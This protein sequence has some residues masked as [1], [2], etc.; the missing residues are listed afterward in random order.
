MSAL[1]WCILSAVNLPAYFLV[2]WALFKDWDEFIEAV[3]F[4]LKPDLWSALS[5]ELMDDWWAEMKL[6]FFLAACTGLVFVEG[7][8][9]VEPHI[10]PL[11]SYRFWSGRIVE[12]ICSYV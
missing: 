6:G 3:V 1:G 4:W 2:G 12:S 8:L 5:G 10:L 11:L 7:A 9:V